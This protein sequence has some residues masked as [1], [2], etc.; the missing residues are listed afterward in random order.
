MFSA[1]MML[2]S[3]LLC[4]GVHT[5]C[6]SQSAADTDGRTYSNPVI[7]ADFSD[8][9]VIRAGD[10]FYLTA[11]SFQCVPGLPVLV[12]HD[13]VNWEILNYALP[14]LLPESVYT[15]PRHGKGVWAP[16]IRVRDGVF[17]IYYCDPDFGLYRVATRDP[18]GTWEPP[19]CLKRVIGWEDPCPFWDDDGRAYLIHAF[20]GSR[21]GRK[22]VLCLHRMSDDGT[23]LL[24][25][26]VLVFDGHAEH[27]TIEGPKLYKRNGYY[28]IFAPAGGVKRG[29]QSV[30]RSRSITGPY[31]ARIVLEQGSTAINGPHQGAWVELPSGESWFLHFQDRAAYGRVVHLQPMCWRDDWPVIGNDADGNGTGEPVATHTVPDAGGHHDRLRLQVSDE[32]NDRRIG[33]QW[34]WQANPESDWAKPFPAEGVLRMYAVPP[35]AGA[36]N[37]TGLP[38]LL[39]QKLPSVAFT[40]TARIVPAFRNDGEGF[41]FVVTGRDYAMAYLHRAG[42]TTILEMR[43]CMDAIG[44]SEEVISGRV[45]VAG[46]PLFLRITVREGGICRWSQSTDGEEFMPLGEPFMATAGIWIGAKIGIVCR[47][48]GFTNDAGWVDVDWLRFDVSDRTQG[49]G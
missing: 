17:M 1:R 34:Q 32:C 8:P 48:E 12:S 18:A 23:Q 39:S 35:V 22:S 24:D 16:S 44:G 7:P 33:L 27:P 14:R 31:E 13:L 15:L 25:D 40:V 4:P 30:L 41:G 47:S 38:N 49:G 28:Y 21:A 20:A 19:I 46:G 11:S 9:D 37:L 2:L 43:T 26:G 10:R 3:L 29:W 45:P 5:L 6:V 36:R 42:D